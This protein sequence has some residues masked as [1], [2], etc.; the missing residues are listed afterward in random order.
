MRR[1]WTAIAIGVAFLILAGVLLV[2]WLPEALPSC[3]SVT[4]NI[5]GAGGTPCGSGLDWD[6]Q[7]IAGVVVAALCAVLALTSFALGLRR[8]PR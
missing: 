3:P 6:A 8:P 5:D 7:S 2:L 4:G 1:D